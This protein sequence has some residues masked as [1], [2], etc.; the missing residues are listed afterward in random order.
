MLYPSAWYFKVTRHILFNDFSRQT[1]RRVKV[2]VSIEA[3]RVVHADPGRHC[4]GREP[5]VPMKRARTIANGAQPFVAIADEQMFLK[6]ERK[7]G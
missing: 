7:E 6:R 3:D 2:R 4:S 1:S 5:G